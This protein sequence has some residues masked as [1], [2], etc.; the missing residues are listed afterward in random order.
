LEQI[1]VIVE[2]DE[3]VRN[4][5]NRNY[6]GLATLKKDILYDFFKTAFDGSG[7]WKG[8]RERGR[9]RRRKDV[10][11]PVLGRLARPKIARMALYSLSA[12]LSADLAGSFPPSLPHSLTHSLTPSLLSPLVP[13]EETISTTQAPVSTVG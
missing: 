6:K 5:V 12:D 13:Q 11:R 7:G 9:K 1:E 2:E 4:L 8:G 3:G 10:L